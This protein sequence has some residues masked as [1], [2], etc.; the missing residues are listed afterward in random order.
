MDEPVGDL[1]PGDVSDK[2][3]APLDGK[4]LVHQQVDGQGTQ[5][6]PDEWRSPPTPDCN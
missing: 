3:P 2:P 4:V 5:P 1:G 6:G